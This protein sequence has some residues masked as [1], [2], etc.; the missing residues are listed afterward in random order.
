[1]VREELTT[2]LK[3]ALTRGESLERAMNSLIS[4]GYSQAEVNEAA[5]SLNLGATANLGIVSTQTKPQVLQ[6]PPV[7]QQPPQTTQIQ[8]AAQTQKIQQQLAPQAPPQIPQTTQVQQTQ[9][10]QAPAYKP[11]P[12]QQAEPPKKSKT[13]LILLIIL[14]VLVIGFIAVA[15]LFGEQIL[16]LLFPQ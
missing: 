10:M 4:A 13:W 5:N 15:V 1:M 3:N 12:I 2:G 14:L 7:Q 16:N 11:L 9:Q 6:A 8:P